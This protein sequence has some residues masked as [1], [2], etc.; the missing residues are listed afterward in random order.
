[1]NSFQQKTNGRIDIKTPNTSKL[2]EMYD[3]IPANQCVTFRNA[4]EGLWD[5]TIL[6]KAY[7]SQE[8]IQILQNGIRVG[9]YNLSNKQYVIHPVNCDELKVVMRSVFLQYSANMSNSIPEQIESLN[10]IVINYCV[11][12]VY[13]EAQGYIKYIN[14]ASTLVIPIAPPV[15]SSNNDKQLELKHWF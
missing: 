8:N 12:Q 13:G 15:M 4:T 2:F 3:K 10:Q 11:Q 14:D 9:V 6:S 5:D 1:M 7:F